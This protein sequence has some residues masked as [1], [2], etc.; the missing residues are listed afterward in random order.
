MKYEGEM[1]RLNASVKSST[2][3]LS[4]SLSLLKVREKRGSGGMGIGGVDT[5]ESVIDQA[6]GQ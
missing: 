6:P 5:P 1:V 3:F 2:R 4:L